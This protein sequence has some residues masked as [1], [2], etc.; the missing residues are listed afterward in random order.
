MVGLGRS[1]G[2]MLKRR[3]DGGDELLYL[4]STSLFHSRGNEHAVADGCA[5]LRPQEGLEAF[6]QSAALGRGR[7]S[8]KPP[9]E[10][11]S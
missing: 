11:Y 7:G 2:G 3:S 9:P 5:N 8:G 6:R 10:W 1:W 4:Q